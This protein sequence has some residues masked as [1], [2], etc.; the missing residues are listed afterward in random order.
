MSKLNIAIVA[1]LLA[2][3][4]VFGSV[5]LF[6]ST[7]LAAASRTATD[8][9]V[10]AKTRQLNAY[11]RTLRTQL[12]AARSPQGAGTAARIVYH[13]PPPIVVVKHTHHDDGHEGGRDD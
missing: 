11:E 3:A 2:L 8:A 13:R 10:A 5:A 12:A 4:V 1:A 9:A 6:R 7:G